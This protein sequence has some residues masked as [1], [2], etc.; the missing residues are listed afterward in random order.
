MNDGR[1][2]GESIAMERKN[3]MYRKLTLKGG[4]ME[5]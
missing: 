3:E 2:K 5:E 4:G 1:S